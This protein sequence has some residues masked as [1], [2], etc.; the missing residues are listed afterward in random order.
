ML[1]LRSAAGQYELTG[2]FS[3][4]ADRTDGNPAAGQFLGN[5]AHRDLAEAQTAIA[6]RQSEGKDA[7]VG[8]LG[9]QVEGNIGIAAV[10]GV[11]VRRDPR[12]GEA[13]HF[14]THPVERLVQAAIAKR[15][16]APAL[17][18]K[19]SDPCADCFAHSIRHKPSGAISA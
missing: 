16:G 15:G 1:L 13:A 9:D 3:A 5:D 12:I 7:E 18:Q 6:F 2:D 17:A 8:K 4:G 19:S 14:L 10:P 11:R